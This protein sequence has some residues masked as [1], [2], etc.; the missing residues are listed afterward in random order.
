MSTADDGEAGTAAPHLR[1]VRGAADEIE[2][3]ALVAGLVAVGS[4]EA[5]AGGHDHALRT[6]GSAWTDRSRTLR[7][8][9]AARPGPDAWRWSRHP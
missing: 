9:V 4:D 8:P 5:S 7:G 1:V 3:A 6:P 2:L